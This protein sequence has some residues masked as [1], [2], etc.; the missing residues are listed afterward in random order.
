MYPIYIKNFRNKALTKL[1]VVSM[2]FN[3]LAV[4]HY[5]VYVPTNPG[6]P[7]N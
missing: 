3:A 5:V 4:G 6:H 2:I 7:A 1:V